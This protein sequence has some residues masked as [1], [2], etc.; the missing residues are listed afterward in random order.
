MS[1]GGGSVN[2]T[3]NHPLSRRRHQ[4]FSQVHARQ[5]TAS[6]RIALDFTHFPPYLTGI[7]DSDPFLYRIH[8]YFHKQI[9][10]G[11]KHAEQ[12]DH[13]DPPYT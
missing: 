6:R 10:F 13:F 9:A 1:G 8:T 12:N 3:L 11:T 4:T 5:Y 7:A 2:S